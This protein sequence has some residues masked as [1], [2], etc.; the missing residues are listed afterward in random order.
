MPGIAYNASFSFGGFSGQV[1]GISVEAGTPEIVDMTGSGDPPGTAVMVPTGDFKP[2]SITVDFLAGGSV[3][4]T[5]TKGQL[6]FNS[7]VYSIGR[8]VVLESAQVEARVGELV[9]GTMKFVMTD[10]Y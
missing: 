4:N 8:N 2:G 5:G 1:T 3:P 6:S 7:S 9:R 10:Y